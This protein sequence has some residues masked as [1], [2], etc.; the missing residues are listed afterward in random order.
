MGVHKFVILIHFS[1][2]HFIKHLVCHFI[3]TISMA[4]KLSK[5]KF[6]A[7]GKEKVTS[8]NTVGEIHSH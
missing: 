8:S 3:S 5:I 4:P 2:K 7:K 6:D 1:F